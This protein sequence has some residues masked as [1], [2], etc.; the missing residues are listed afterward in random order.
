[1]LF[2]LFMLFV[3]RAFCPDLFDHVGKRLDK[4]GKVNF[5]T[6]DATALEANNCNTHISQYL[7]K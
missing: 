2:M 6:Y 4:K 1:M 3:K 5:K 7:K